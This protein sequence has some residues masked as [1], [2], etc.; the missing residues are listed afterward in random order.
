MNSAKINA[1]AEDVNPYLERPLRAKHNKQ[2]REIDSR[3]F[4]T[5]AASKEFI[6][7]VLEKGLACSRV[8]TT[9]GFLVRVLEMVK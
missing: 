8:R 3:K 2:V 4:A 6:D 9:E 7:F 5:K 1:Y